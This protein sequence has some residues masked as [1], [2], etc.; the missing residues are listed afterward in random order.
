MNSKVRKM[1]Y[2]VNTVEIQIARR[3]LTFIGRGVRMDNN[4]VPSKLTSS[5]IEGKKSR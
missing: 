3:R 1:L 4:K 2:N 5:W